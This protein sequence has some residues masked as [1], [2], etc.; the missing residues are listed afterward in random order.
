MAYV[1]SATAAREVYSEPKSGAAAA[2]KPGLLRRMFTALQE[3]RMRDAEREI[4][5]YLARSGG[6]FTDESEREI[7]RRIFANH[8]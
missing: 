5:R 4:A 7:E 1:H 8:N 6:R 3:A 2:R